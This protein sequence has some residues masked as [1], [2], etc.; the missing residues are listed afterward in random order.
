MSNICPA[1]GTPKF[2]AGFVSSQNGNNNGNN[3]GELPQSYVY[4]ILL[5]IGVAGPCDINCELK[6]Q[7]SQN[8]NT[9]SARASKTKP[10]WQ[11]SR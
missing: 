8:P 6:G 10:N 4:P 3:N 1:A 2:P 9:Q 7:K 5:Q 11:Q